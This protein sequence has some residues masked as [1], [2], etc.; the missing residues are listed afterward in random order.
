MNF[1]TDL[2][3]WEDSDIIVSDT[4]VDG[5]KKSYSWER[6]YRLIFA[7]VVALGCALMAYLGVLFISI[8]VTYKLQECSFTVF[9]L[10][11]I[12]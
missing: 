10:I 3:N 11:R 7:L 12:I 2:L 1:I 8:G 5:N 9:Y 4:K 6:V